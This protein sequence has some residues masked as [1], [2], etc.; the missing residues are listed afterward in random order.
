M[1]WAEIPFSKFD[2]IYFILFLFYF[3]SKDLLA[4]EIGGREDLNKFF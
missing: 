2:Q 1:F 4:N 3:W